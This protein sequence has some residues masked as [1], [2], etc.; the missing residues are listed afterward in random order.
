MLTYLTYSQF[1]T[2]MGAP[3]NTIVITSLKQSFDF[4]Q[5]ITRYCDVLLI[6]NDLINN[7]GTVTFHNEINTIFSPSPFNGKDNSINFRP[8]RSSNIIFINYLERE[9]QSPFSLGPKQHQY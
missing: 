2:S 6:F 9:Y 1:I 3:P 7:V 8:S 5:H 4:A